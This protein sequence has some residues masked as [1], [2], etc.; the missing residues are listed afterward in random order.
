MSRDFSYLL[1][2]ISAMVVFFIYL[3]NVI[4]VIFPQKTCLVVVDQVVS[5]LPGCLSLFR[6][7][8]F[9]LSF[10]AWVLMIP[11]ATSAFCP[12]L[13]CVCVVRTNLGKKHWSPWDLGTWGG[14]DLLEGEGCRRVGEVARGESE[15]EEGKGARDICSCFLSAAEVLGKGFSL[16]FRKRV[17]CSTK[18]YLYTFVFRSIH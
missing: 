6:L 2:L 8:L 1:V 16:V 5:N 11:T 7:H 3:S 9:T 13:F 17:V 14:L 12:N 15:Q 18:V 10:C 4:L